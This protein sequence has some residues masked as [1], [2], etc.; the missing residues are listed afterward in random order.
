MTHN[1]VRDS[2]SPHFRMLKGQNKLPFL[3]LIYGNIDSIKAVLG[4]EDIKVWTK[5]FGCP[6][7]A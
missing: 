5:V 4:R 3:M 6:D 1:R 2:F 7:A